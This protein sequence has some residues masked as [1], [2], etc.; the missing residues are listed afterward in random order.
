MEPQDNTGALA[1]KSLREADF[2]NHDVHK[3]LAEAERWNIEWL[4]NSRER[5]FERMRNPREFTG[6]SLPWSKAEEQRTRA[7]R[8]KSRTAKVGQP[9]TWPTS[10]Q[11]AW[12]KPYGA[13]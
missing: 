6:F 1:L 5:V 11:P 10:G 12:T 8:R 4:S 7:R 3:I 2:S 13:E 9:M